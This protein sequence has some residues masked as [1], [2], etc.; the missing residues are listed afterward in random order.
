MKMGISIS[1]D[2]EK[3]DK[4]RIKTGNN[5]KKYLNLTSFVDPDNPGKYGDHGFITQQKDKNEDVKMPICGNVKVFWQEVSHETP[6]PPPGVPEGY[7]G[8]SPH[9]YEDSI[10]F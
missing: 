3:I 6:T 9:D 8:V 1:V 4:A 7:S 5:G 2:L 10:P